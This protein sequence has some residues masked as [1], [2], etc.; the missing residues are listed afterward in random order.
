MNDSFDQT[1]KKILEILQHEGRISNLDLARRINLSP[2]ATLTRVRRL[3]AS[4]IIADYVALLA[5]ERLGYDMMCFVS[6]T[7]QM[8]QLEQVERFRQAVQAMPQV[9]ECHHV[10]GDHDY[11]LKVVVQN[12]QDLEHF[13]MQY[14]TP[15]QGIAR[16]QTSLVLNEIKQTTVLPIPP[17][18]DSI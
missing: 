9:L 4:G 8:H 1:D 2:P 6:V 17:P 18:Q 7:L 11:L 5:R 10:T 13:V 15:I 12:R 3:E 14:L 16:I